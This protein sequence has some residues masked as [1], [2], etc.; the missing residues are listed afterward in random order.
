METFT[1]GDQPNQERGLPDA[2]TSDGEED[3]DDDVNLKRRAPHL[4]ATRGDKS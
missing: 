4:G 2:E 3:D 1:Q